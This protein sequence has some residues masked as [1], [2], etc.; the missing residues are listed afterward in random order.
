MEEDFEIAHLSKGQFFAGE[1][2]KLMQK[3]NIGSFWILCRISDKVNVT[4][5]P[6]F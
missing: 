1:Y 4:N 3:K 2:N 5:L 6:N